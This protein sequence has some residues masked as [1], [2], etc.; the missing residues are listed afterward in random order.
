MSNQRPFAP[1]ASQ[2]TTNVNAALTVFDGINEVLRLLR[3]INHATDLHSKH[4][5]KAT[6]LTTPQLI[7]LKA[8]HELGEVTAGAIAEHVSLSAGTV[9]ILLDRLEGHGLIERYRS[10]RDRRV[11]HARLTQ[12]GADVV[13]RAPALMRDKF[14]ERFTKMN[15]A[16]Q[17]KSLAVLKSIADMM[18]ADDVDEQLI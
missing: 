7:V 12:K 8:I 11:A 9:S 16:E 6:G 17:E 14:I 13:A 5:I 18:D 4:L 15:S 2:V 1:L 3:R 10:T